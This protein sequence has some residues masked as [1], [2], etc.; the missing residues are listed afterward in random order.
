[1]T[2]R[3]K[4]VCVETSMHPGA[5]NTHGVKFIPVYG[6]SEENKE[7][8]T[9]TPSGEFK[10]IGLKNQPFVVGKEYYIDTTDVINTSGILAGEGKG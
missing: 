8:F 4:F 2:N 1:M 7:F 9:Y 6:G 3:C 10:L 5:P